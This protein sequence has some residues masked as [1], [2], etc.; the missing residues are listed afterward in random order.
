MV[1][2]CVNPINDLLR[3]LKKDLFP[4]FVNKWSTHTHMKETKNCNLTLTVDGNW[5]LGRNKCVYGDVAIQSPEFGNVVLGCRYSPQKGSY[6]CKMHEGLDIKYNY[7]G[8]QISLNPAMIKSSNLGM[9][10]INV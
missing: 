10:N 8:Q 6:Y 9:L 2:A 3:D 4:C 5:K 1:S 7:C